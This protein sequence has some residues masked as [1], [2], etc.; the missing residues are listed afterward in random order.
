MA[1]PRDA[2][3]GDG[4]D[5]DMAGADETPAEAAEDAA[6]A[7][8]QDEDDEMDGA[9]GAEERAASSAPAPVA[10]AMMH[11]AIE[12]VPASLNSDARTVD[13]V[14]STGADV[15]RYDWWKDAEYT[16][17]L[18]MKPAS[19]RL[20]RL[21][22]GAPLLRAHEAYDLDAVIGNVVPG[23]AKVD[24]K[25]GTATVQFANS[26]DGERYFGLVKQGVLRFLSAG[27]QTYRQEI[28]ATVTPELRTAVDWEPFEISVVPIPADADAAFRA[29]SP[30]T[31]PAPATTQEHRMPD[32]NPAAVQPAA[33]TI[34]PPIVT[35]EQRAAI[36]ASER[37]RIAGIRAVGGKL[38]LAPDFISQH[39]TA[40]T[41]LD[42]FRIQAIDA[43]AA[44][45]NEGAR[46][47]SAPAGGQ[48]FAAARQTVPGINV[49][50]FL[51]AVAASNSR[52]LDARGIADWSANR[53][54]PEGQIV[55]R[56]L[57]VSL[58]SAGGFTVPADMAAELVP[59]LRPASA[60][61][62]LGPRILPM[63]NG[64]ITVPRMD[65][66][67]TATYVGELGAAGAT[68][69]TFGSVDLIA[70][71]LNAWVPMSKDMIRYP[72]L[73][74]ETQ[75]RDDAV[76]AIAQRADLAF[77][78]GD[79]SNNT[80]RGMES[81]ILGDAK[82]K[83][84]NWIEAT[85][86]GASEA[87]ATIVNRT[88]QDLGKLKAALKNANLPMTKPGWI[89]DP[90]R[91]E[92]LLNLSDGLGGLAFGEEMLAQKTLLG[93]PWRRT[94]QIPTNRTAA[95]GTNNTV[96]L[97]ADFAEV[98]IGEAQ[99]LEVSAFDQSTYTDASGNVIN[100][101]QADMIALMV[102]TQHD[103]ALRQKYA[104]AE[105]YAVG[106]SGGQQAQSSA[107]GFWQ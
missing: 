31:R 39:E 67:S 48:V 87:Q 11:R 61:M 93:Y 77:M 15:R 55:A 82:V 107:A 101:A 51:I 65:G 99:E 78:V 100:M 53:W 106:G 97:F 32:A 90:T 26:P 21:N 43:A 20:G 19:V 56:A 79:G 12:T 74:V 69:P 104:A 33:A 103:F 7:G 6:E 54:G 102:Q 59:F 2:A 36:L 34:T 60:V 81:F 84:A 80:P 37:E 92:F 85:A 95:S 30:T 23:T 35:D 41:P 105:L 25:R 91:E 44:N 18:D 24:G 96:I 13:V 64:N 29:F 86:Q 9:S 73:D 75:V 28:D 58:G 57:S 62:S 50:R 5:D 70:R 8:E 52:R 49:G 17:R 47:F 27:Y 63:P 40:G 76:R 16:E 88:R 14:W 38:R 94:T 71:K 66:G 98:Y 83:A 22:K 72:S 1:K 46:A 45:D 42:A 89:M 4:P 68:Q 10:P 3:D